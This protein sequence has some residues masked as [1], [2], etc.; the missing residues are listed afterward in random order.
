VIAALLD[1]LWQ[2]SLVA[3]LAACLTLTV[4]RKGRKGQQE[5]DAGDEPQPEAHPRR[6]AAYR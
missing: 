4:R 3:L 1:H 5:L 2:S 6:V